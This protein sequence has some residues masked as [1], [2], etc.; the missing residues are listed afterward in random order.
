MPITSGPIECVATTNDVL[1]EIPLWDPLRRELGWVDLLGARLNRYDPATGTT[2][3][4]PIREKIG[5]WCLAEDDSVLLA[6]RS[7][8]SRWWPGSDRY[9]DLARPEADRP[10][11]IMNDGRCDPAGRFLFGSMDRMIAGPTGRLWSV[12]S[13]SAPR[14]L[15]DGGIF[16][17]NGLCWSPCG[18]ILYVGDTEK[19]LIFAHPY[20][21]ASGTIGEARI[22][23]DTRSLGG[24]LDGCSVDEEGHVWHVRFGTG[25]VVRFDPTG[26]VDRTWMMPTRQP[27]HLTFGGPDLSTLFV[28]TARFRLPAEVLAEEPAAG[29]LLAMEVGVRGLPEA[30]F[31]VAASPVGEAED[32]DHQ[33]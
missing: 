11:N 24:R 9:Q 32:R 6:G 31:G 4:T 2:R 33:I 1:G 20:D 23:A 25:M 17:P 29:S 10:S 15:I 3:V 13:G 16:I 22:F 21:P 30:R 7:G 8:L 26:R 5:A 27:T 12:E 18:R 19:D 28:T 14:A